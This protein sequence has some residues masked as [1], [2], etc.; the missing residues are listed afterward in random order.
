MT[1]ATL[2]EFIDARATV[3]SLTVE[4]YHQMIRAGIL[5]EGAP[6]ELL[7]GFLV[8]KDRAKA[9]QNPMTVG[10]EHAWAVGQLTRLVAEIERLGAQL[11]IQQPITLPPDNEPEPDAA[12]VRGDRDYR[13]QHPAPADI[14]CLIE[15][16]DSSLHH[17]R[18]TKQRIYAA[19]GI[20]QY[21]IIN[22]IDRVVEEYRHLQP[23]TGR[24][25]P[26]RL[27]RP[28]D[29]LALDAGPAGQL[30]LAVASLLP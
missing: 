26:P 1:T 2:K 4:Q 6:I 12:I 8:H 21:I 28:G 22:L 15:V 7:D 30:T 23:P 29:T 3:V 5:T 10:T 11:R 19:A 17:D 20:G 16:A 25:A 13:R 24:Y 27:Y 9:G 14:H 18:T